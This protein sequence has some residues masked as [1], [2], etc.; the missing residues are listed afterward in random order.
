MTQ[1]QQRGRFGAAPGRGSSAESSKMVKG[2]L[3]RSQL[4]ST[5]GIGS[6]YEMRAYFG[7]GQWVTSV[8][9]DGLE[10]W[11]SCLHELEPIREAVLE[12][13]LGVHYF[14]APPA[15]QE[16]RYTGPPAN[17]PAVPVSLFP[18]WQVCSECDRL[19]K[20]GAE[21]QLRTGRLRCEA[22]DC[23]GH[24]VPVRLVVT[25]Y[26]REEE[27][28][29]ST[30][31]PGHLDDFP[32]FLWAHN[33]GKN[34]P[35]K[36]LPAQLRL[37]STGRSA[38]LAG[39][40][41]ECLHP[42]CRKRKIGQ[43]LDGVFGKGAL[44]FMS[45]RGKRP[46]LH[47]KEACDRPVRALM[48]GASNVYFPVVASALSIPPNSTA[49]INEVGKVWRRTV[50]P[51]LDTNP[52]LAE[53]IGNFIEQFRLI[54]TLKNASPVLRR[55]FSEAQI[56]DAINRQV[57]PEDYSDLPATEWE[58]RS[59]ERRAIVAGST[60]DDAGAECLFESE[61]VGEDAC[62]AAGRELSKLV[63]NLVRVQR[64]REVR[65]L[66]GFQRLS[67]EM[68]GDS[69]TAPC[70][71]LSV[72]K[73]HWLPA[74]TVQGEGIYFE[75]DSDAVYN[76]KHR[77]DVRRRVATVIHR[78]DALRGGV[79]GGNKLITPELI[80]LHT[81]AHLLISQLSL[82]CGY[83]SASLRER[84]YV[85]READNTFYCGVL[86]YTASSSSD[87]TLGGLVRQG[88][89]DLFYST[90]ETAIINATWCSSDPLCIES[91]GQGV[92]ALNLAACHACCITSETSCEMR[93]SFLDRGLVV[94]TPDLPE[95]G[96]FSDYLASH[97]ET[98]GSI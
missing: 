41:V 28:G 42:E 62:V 23:E 19:G 73:K 52:A 53:D 71:P 75:L 72:N 6:L 43:S 82:D 92:E 7:T 32:W 48:R 77:E 35:C 90:L 83:S 10:S 18:E 13:L 34:M 36:G 95:I 49:C 74:I 81:V 91:D 11:E 97:V 84:I 67:S 50:R 12:R 26:C 58:Q 21:F 8:I 14:V 25:C 59:S 39:M 38:G 9:I 44:N 30:H 63:C 60:C 47:D 69:Y 64:L 5:Y 86:I 65:V 79:A 80:L 2:S 68:S 40:R 29:V 96:F 89:P 24:A 45:C 4:V 31:H 56:R 88:D 27:V 33:G 85:S 94:G 54:E 93:N 22:T 57:S 51:L 20:V 37:K 61:V 78:L 17:G 98:G 16:T 70:A 1:F 3:S 55:G 66:R 87:G 46:W 15:E 76:W